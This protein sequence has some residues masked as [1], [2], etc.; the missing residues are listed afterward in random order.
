MTRGGKREGAGRPKEAE[1][2][3]GVTVMLTDAELAIVDNQRGKGE[4]RS[5]C[6]RRVLTQPNYLKVVD[7]T[8]P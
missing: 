4:S 5:A 1:R 6:I 7:F 8:S 2:R 3:R